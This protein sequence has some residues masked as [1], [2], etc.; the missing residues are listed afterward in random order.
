MTGQSVSRHAVT[1]V[2]ITVLLD[3]IGFGLI[4]PVLP[5]LI[6]QV[7]GVDL[8]HAALIGGWMFFA[9]SITQFVFSPLVGNLSDRFGRRPLLLLAIFGL[10]VDYLFSAWA[11]S[12]FWLFVGRAIAGLCGSSYVIANAYIADV[13]APEDRARAFGLMGAAF[14]IG[15]V[16]GPAIG[17]MLGEFGPR[18][19][20]LVAAAIS[21]ANL[22][23]GWFVLPE[24]LPP[25]KRR[26]FQWRRANP[27]GT[28]AVFRRYTGVLPLCGVLFVF[29]FASS[30][31]PAIWPFWGM[32]KFDWSVSMVGLTLAAFGIVAAFFQGV[33]AGP[34]VT[35]FGEHR[36]AL[37]G[38]CVA[39]I[40]ALGYGLVGTL[41]GVVI[42]LVIHGP[43]GFV[44]P[45]LTAIMSKAVP[46]DAQGE[47][48]GGISAVMNVAMLMGTVTFSQIFGF[49]MRPDAPVQSPD[50]AFFAAASVLLFALVLYLATVRMLPAPVRAG[51]A[52]E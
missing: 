32:A 34:A 29:F 5:G 44:H 14:G 1:F 10:F 37:L 39:V 27:F 50:I 2:M 22:V 8:S 12:V 28:F 40:A 48:Q 11:P 23:Y 31:Y 46:E 45:M 42:M 47:L 25:E 20:F 51:T 38:L 18:V 4:I 9:F 52:A 49:F 24:T 3:M 35:R 7:G 41:A 26:P 19:P 30:V 36:V 6:E 17:G 33:L 15:F 43:E 13:T 16:I 21:A